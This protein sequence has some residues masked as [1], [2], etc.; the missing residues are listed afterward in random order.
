MATAEKNH[1]IRDEAPVSHFT[2]IP[3]LVDDSGLSAVAIRLYLHLKRVAGEDGICWQSQIQLAEAC[4][5]NHHTIITAKRALEGA[6]L[7]RI[8]KQM[9]NGHPIHVIVILDVWAANFEFYRGAQYKRGTDLS[10][11]EASRLVQKEHCKNTPRRITI[12]NKDNNDINNVLIMG[13]SVGKIR[14]ILANP[15]SFEARN[16]PE[17][18]KEVWRWE[19]KS[20]GIPLEA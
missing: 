19:L 15:D 9:L 12:K 10:I 13:Q 6:G 14:R 20:R 8:E 3:H 18:S 2:M 7:I 16:V 1:F 4:R 11:K 17:R 5:L